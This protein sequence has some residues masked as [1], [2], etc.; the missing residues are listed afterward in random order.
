[1]FVTPDVDCTAIYISERHKITYKRRLE[2]GIKGKKYNYNIIIRIFLK[3]ILVYCVLYF[4]YIQ[5]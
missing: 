4:T 2:K 1:M 5:F 3:N